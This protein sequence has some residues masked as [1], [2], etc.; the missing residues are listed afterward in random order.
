[1]CLSRYKRWLADIA[2]VLTPKIVNFT[3][4]K[5]FVGTYSAAKSESTGDITYLHS[6]ISQ[7]YI[8]TNQ[9]GTE[10]AQLLQ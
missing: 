9:W 10:L 5:D 7:T 8:T 3:T 6:R 4:G 1:M 2:N